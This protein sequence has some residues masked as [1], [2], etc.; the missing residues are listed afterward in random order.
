MRNIVAGLLAAVFVMGAVAT[1]DACPWSSKKKEET[2][3][4]TS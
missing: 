2:T 4:T 3:S 1:A